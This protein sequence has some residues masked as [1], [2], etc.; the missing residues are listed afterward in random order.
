MYKRQALDHEGHTLYIRHQKGELG[1]HFE[2]L[3][4]ALRRLAREINGFSY[5]DYSGWRCLDGSSST[6]VSYTHLDVY[7]RQAPDCQGTVKGKWLLERGPHFMNLHET[8]MGQRFFNVQLPALINTLKDIA[9]ALSRP[10]PSAI[11]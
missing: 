5:T 7:K 9:A 3:Y 10:A 6:P 8:A 4:I 1:C 11:S 2:R